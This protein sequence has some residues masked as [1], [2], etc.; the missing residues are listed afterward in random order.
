MVEAAEILGKELICLPS[1][2][3]NAQAATSPSRARD[4]GLIG[5]AEPAVLA[6]ARQL[7]AVKKAYGR[8]TIAVGE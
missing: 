3:L 6:L 1:K 7:I 5:V 8:V 4:L 2:V